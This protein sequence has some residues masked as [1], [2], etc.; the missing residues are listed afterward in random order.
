MSKRLSGRKAVITGAGTGIGRGVAI[1]F[2][3]EG[4]DVVLHYASNRTGAETAAAECAGLGVRAFIRGADL[5]SPRACLSLID[6]AVTS[7]GGLDILV[8]N[9]GVTEKADFLSV[10]PEDFDRLYHINVRG[11]FFCAQQAV[12]HMRRGGGGVLVNLTSVLGLGAVPGVS[13]YAGTKGAIAAW[14]RQLAVELAPTIRVNAVAPGMI[15][16]PRQAITNPGYDPAREG[17]LIPMQRVGVPH[18]IAGACVFLASDA[19]SFLTG[20]VLVVDGG[21]TAWLS[22]GAARASRDGQVGQ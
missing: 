2:A 21:T 18:D 13:V 16:V 14:T 20:Q 19:S 9:S 3:R 17:H 7:L 15:D 11:Q 12:R 6:E 10:T 1:E 8:N 5:G 4:A 22:L